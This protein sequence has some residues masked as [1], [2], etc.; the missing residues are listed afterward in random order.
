MSSLSESRE[1]EVSETFAKIFQMLASDNLTP[2]EHLAILTKLII[3]IL[4]IGKESGMIS[5]ETLLQA[6][7]KIVTAILQGE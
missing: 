1:I 6:K 5:K 3:A 7:I 2:G 4:E